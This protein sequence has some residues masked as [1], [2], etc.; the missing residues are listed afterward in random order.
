[1]QQG[2]PSPRSTIVLL[3]RNWKRQ[4]RK[5]RRRT[6]LLHRQGELSS[7]RNH[8]LKRQFRK[9]AATTSSPGFQNSPELQA[10]R[11]PG[12]THEA[13]S[14]SV[15]DNEASAI[16]LEGL[17]DLADALIEPVDTGALSD[18]S[19]L[20]D[21]TDVSHSGAEHILVS[22]SDAAPVSSANTRAEGPPPI[23]TRE[24]T[25]V[26]VNYGRIVK[27]MKVQ[28]LPSGGSMQIRLDPPEMGAL[29][30]PKR[31]EPVVHTPTAN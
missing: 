25:F 16:Q 30:E 7:Q 22:P 10:A 29:S 3:I 5:I 28:L 13:E 23:T 14:Q 27:E 24:D 11:Q 17:D 1:M 6:A 15:D 21:K 19:V 31:N 8:R 2:R 20:P 9:T 4:C 12:A 26:E 18:G